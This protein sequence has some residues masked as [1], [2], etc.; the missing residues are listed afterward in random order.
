MFVRLDMLPHG[1]QVFAVLLLGGAVAMGAYG[2]GELGWLDVAATL[3][4][5]W[6]LTFGQLLMS[7]RKPREGAAFS[8]TRG[9]ISA[10]LDDWREFLAT[11][12]ILAK[13][14]LAVAS[15]VGF[16]AARALV[17]WGLGALSNPWL[18]GAFGLVIASLVASPVLWKAIGGSLGADTSPADGRD[19]VTARP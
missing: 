2:L 9:I 1:W 3:L 5:A 19:D 7:G 6:G 15:A 10:A 18:A 13:A 12:A 11:R 16:V 14:V 17:A 4:T 8:K